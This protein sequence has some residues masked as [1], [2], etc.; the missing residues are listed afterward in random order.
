[1]S[2]FTEAGARCAD[3]ALGWSMRNM[4]DLEGKKGS[5]HQSEKKTAESAAPAGTNRASR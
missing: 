3:A 4:A 2:V 5:E 1:M